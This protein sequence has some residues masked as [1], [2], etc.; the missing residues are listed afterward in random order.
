VSA[1]AGLIRRLRRSV[2]NRVFERSEETNE[3]VRLDELGLAQKGYHDYEP[4]GWRSL[5]RAL[6]GLDIGPSDVFLDIGCG[7]GRVVAQAARR[8]FARVLGVELSEELAEQARR[9]AES[10]RHRQRCGSVEI[11]NADVT[12]WQMPDHVTIA[13]IYN[14]LSGAPLGAALDRIAESVSRAPRR[15]LLLYVNH[16]NEADVIAHPS[17]DL[18]ERRGSRRWSASDPRRISIFEVGP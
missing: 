5:N 14:A 15:L 2:L 1:T 12:T 11:V 3:V 17:F 18:L 4:S 6:Q 13:Y 10:E 9:L 7:K 8:P 16:L